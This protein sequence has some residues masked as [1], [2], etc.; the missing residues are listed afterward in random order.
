MQRFFV[1]QKRQRVGDVGKP[2][3]W[4]CPGPRQQ[5]AVPAIEWEP[6][7]DPEQQED[8]DEVEWELRFIDFLEDAPPGK[9]DDWMVRPPNLAKISSSNNNM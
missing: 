9:D 2:A 8:Q 6:E 3:T 5:L 7:Q 4:V 1:H